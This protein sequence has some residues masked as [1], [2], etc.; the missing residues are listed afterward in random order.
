MAAAAVCSP[1]PGWMGDV[2]ALPPAAVAECLGRQVAELEVLQAMYG[3]EGE[4]STDEAALTTAAAAAEQSDDGEMVQLPALTFELTLALEEVPSEPRLRLAFVLPPGYPRTAPSVV[5]GC[6]A[7]QRGVRDE[8]AQQLAATAAE[9]TDEL[10]E[11]GGEECLYE[12]V[13]QAVDLVTPLAAAAVAE[14]GGGGAAAGAGEEEEEEEQ[15]VVRI[16][17][18]NSSRQYLAK[19]RKWAD[20]LGLGA[21]VWHRGQVGGRVEGVVVVLAGAADGVGGWLS[22]L[23]SEYVDTDSKGHKVGW[24]LHPAPP[25]PRS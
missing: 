9:R 7:L 23:R 10:A 2:D 6:A 12:L 22:R 25:T 18:M 19:L 16:D 11:E 3:G 4:F 17:H 8:V 24:L 15:C 14:P 13:Q 1:R 5:V 20:Q 21:H